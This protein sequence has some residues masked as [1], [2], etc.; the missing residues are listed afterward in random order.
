MIFN[1]NLY[2]ESVEHV[3]QMLAKAGINDLKTLVC[4]GYLR[5]NEHYD[6]QNKA[7]IAI[8]HYQAAWEE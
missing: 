1:N 2:T 7:F 8:K 5:A 4:L 3:E 6:G